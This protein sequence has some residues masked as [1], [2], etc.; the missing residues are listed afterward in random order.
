MRHDGSK[1]ELRS[2]KK[3]PLQGYSN[4]N[5]QPLLSNG[6]VNMFPRQPNHEGYDRHERNDRGTAGGGVLHWVRPEAIYQEPK[7]MGGQASSESK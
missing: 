6:P 3:H 4:L 7:L 5:S 1:P 2:K